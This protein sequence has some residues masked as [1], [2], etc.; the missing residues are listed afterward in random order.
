MKNLIILTS[1]FPFIGG[2]QFIE[3]EIDYWENSQFHNVYLLPAKKNM[4]IRDYPK[5]IILLDGFV[6]KNSKIDKFI[7]LFKALF[8]LIFWKELYFIV[9]KKEN[10]SFYNIIDALFVSANIE[11]CKQSIG[12][13]IRNIDG[14][15]TIYSYWNDAQ[16]YAS[17]LLK[18][19]GKIKQ[20]VSRAHGGDLYEDR[21]RKN[22][23]PLKAQFKNDFDKVYLLS[24]NAAIYCREKYGYPEKNLKI[25]RLGVN[26]PKKNIK[27]ETHPFKIRI[28]SLSY[29]VPV[30]RIDKIIAT[31]EKISLINKKVTFE[32][33]HIGD[34]PLY[35][36]L[37]NFSQEKLNCFNN[38]FYQF[39]G[40][41]SNE[42]VKK[43]LSE[44]NYDV[45]L[46]VSESE[47]IPVSIME[48]MSY[49]IPTIAPNIGGISDLVN[50]N[51][52]WLLSSE[53][54]VSEIVEKLSLVI[55]LL[56]ED[57]IDPYRKNS[58]F[59]VEKYFNAK[60][61]YEKFIKEVESLVHHE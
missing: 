45:F 28:L 39:I 23:M 43:H 51:N 35:D 7:Y 59:W 19:S 38:I 55:K 13:A 9:F 33:T 20:V 8:C 2:E 47:G 34:G 50:Q 17:C 57:K 5:K 46:N 11:R 12:K 61:N 10:K 42:D 22:Y 41:L 25:A 31:L 14:D 36:D 56:N 40:S 37:L 4:E 32:W 15:I 52:G 6:L 3:S 18:R 58:K 27:Y 49:G 30:K 54:K 24:V 60:K 44:N 1:F 29:C 16:F 53:A 21:R 48:A 26:P